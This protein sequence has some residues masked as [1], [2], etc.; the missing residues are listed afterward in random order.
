M[1]VGTY[2]QNATIVMMSAILPSFVRKKHL[3]RL[4]LKRL[5]HVHKNIPSCI[6]RSLYTPLTFCTVTSKHNDSSIEKV[7]IDSGA[8]DHFFANQAYF[9]TYKEYHLEFQTGSG[10]ILTAHWYGDVVLRLAHLDGSEVTWT[11]KKVSWALSLGHNL[12]STTPLARKWIGV[13]FRQPHISSEISHHGSFFGVA[14]IL[15]TSMLF[16]QQAVFQTAISIKGSSMQSPLYLLRH[17]I[18]KWVT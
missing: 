18:G 14:D 3:H 11:I 16:V 10:E 6:D 12:L 8:T 17:G 13:F 15:I 1:S 5:L 2:K 7:I 4:V 9:S